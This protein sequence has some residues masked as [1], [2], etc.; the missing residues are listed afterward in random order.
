METMMTRDSNLARMKQLEA[1]NEALV[2]GLRVEAAAH[3][4]L[5]TEH[6]ALQDR[7]ARLEAVE[8]AMRSRWSDRMQTAARLFEMDDQGSQ[9][10]SIVESAKASEALECAEML[11]AALARFLGPQDPAQIIAG[12]KGEGR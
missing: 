9:Q 5:A 11:R 7:V 10:A 2:K 3:A 1:E 8:R 12:L 6:A 4:T